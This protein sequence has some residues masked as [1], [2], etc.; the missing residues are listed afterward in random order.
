DVQE[1]TAIRDDARRDVKQALEQPIA[2]S[3]QR[4]D[5]I[6][7]A[8]ANART[9]GIGHVLWL[10]VK[11]LHEFEPP[12]GPPGTLIC[13]P[14][15]GERIGEEKELHGLYELLRQVLAERC[16]GRTAFALTA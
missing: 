4:R 7:M 14:P 16:R 5:V 13:N 10:G 1:W 15:Y 6:D 8:Y 2:G 12:P 3:D 11:S 9:A